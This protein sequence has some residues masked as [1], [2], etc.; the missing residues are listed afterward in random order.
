MITEEQLD[1]L[2]D[3]GKEKS[4]EYCDRWQFSIDKRN[5]RSREFWVFCF[6]NEVDGSLYRIKELKDF[7]DLKNVYHAITNKELEIK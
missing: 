1:T 6:F 4:G 7:D 2:A 3:F 5:V